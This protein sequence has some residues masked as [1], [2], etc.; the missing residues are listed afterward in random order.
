VASIH[1]PVCQP[2]GY[3][4]APTGRPP[5][6]GAVKRCALKGDVKIVGLS[7]VPCPIGCKL[8]ALAKGEAY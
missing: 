6:Y 4:T 5:R 3:A 2:T 7:S 8:G 1:A